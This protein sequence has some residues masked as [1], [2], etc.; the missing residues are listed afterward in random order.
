MNNQIQEKFVLPSPVIPK[1]SYH[2][3]KTYRCLSCSLG[4]QNIFDL[5]MHQLV[6]S[7]E[8]VICDECNQIFSTAKGMKQHYGKIHAKSRPSRCSAC[9][10]R[11]R[12]KYALKF[13]FKQVHEQS[14]RQ[15]CAGCNIEVYNSYSLKRHQKKCKALTDPQN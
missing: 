11:F 10:K 13:H 15:I 14:T 6:D 9:K 12:N 1:Y 5:R 7:E 4:F 3:Y 2:K 8:S